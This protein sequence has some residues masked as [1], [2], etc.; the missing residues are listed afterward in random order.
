MYN[1]KNGREAPQ[2]GPSEIYYDREPARTV[3]QW[4]KGMLDDGLYMPTQQGWGDASGAALQSWKVGIN[5]G[6][7]AG[8]GRTATIAEEASEP[9]ELGAAPLF[10]P[11]GDRFGNRIGGG[12]LFVPRQ[13]V[14]SD[15]ERQA[16]IEFFDWITSPQPQAD[17]YK[18]T[19]YF[20]VNT[21]SQSLLEN[22][23]FFEENPAWT[24]GFRSLEESQNGP[25]TR[26]SIVP[27][28]PNINQDIMDTW[29][30]I[31]QGTPVDEA[32]S[33]QKETIDQKLQE[34]Q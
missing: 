9:F 11:S 22:E 30:S 13:A 7:T 23:G 3:Y 28:L 15:S 29:T 34:N 1:N 5:L 26:M 12:S 25:T 10:S 27:Q 8:L 18:R 19:G 31:R 4:W 33:T 14:E 6:S 24:A 2:S 16:V 17:W 20:P 21:E 32:L